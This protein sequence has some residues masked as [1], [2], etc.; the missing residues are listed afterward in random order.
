MGNRHVPIIL[1]ALLVALGLYAASLYSYLLFHSL[2]ELFSVVVACGIFMIAWNSRQFSQNSYLLFLGIAYLTVACVDTLHMLAYKGMGVFSGTDTNPGTQLWIAARYLEALSFL[3][4]LLLMEVKIKA[5][6]IFAGY[7][8]VFVFLVLSIFSWESFPACFVEGKGLTPFK[9]TSEYAICL[10]LAFSAF[11]LYRKRRLFDRE[12]L[13]LVMASLMITTASELLFTFYVHAYGLF[14]FMGHLLKIASFYLIYRAFI[15]AGLA[16]PYSLLFRN[17]KAS[18]EAW[19][20]GEKKYRAL[21]ETLREGIWAVD[22]DACTTYVNPRMAEMLGCEAGDILGKPPFAFM[23]ERWVEPCKRKLEGQDEDKGQPNDFEFI[24]KDGGRLHAHMVANPLRDGLGRFLGAIAAVSDITDRKRV[25]NNLKRELEVNAALAEL[26]KTLVS[27]SS[28]MREI[29]GMI[30]DKSKSLTGSPCGYASSIDP[31]TKA[32]SFQA[33]A[34]LSEDQCQN[35][36]AL[37]ASIRDH[38]ANRVGTFVNRL[39]G[40][41]QGSTPLPGGSVTVHRL[42]CVPV[43][44]GNEPVGQLAL[45]NKEGDYHEKD[46]EAVQRIAVHYAFAVQRLRFQEALR[47][48]HDELGLRVRQRTT[49]LLKINDELVKEI[50]VRRQAENALKASEAELR[51]LSGQLISAEERERKR[52]ALDL[53]DGI[54][55]TLSAIKF[56]T[57]SA[58]HRILTKQQEAAVAHL[59]SMTTMTQKAIEDVRRILMDLRPSILDDLG[60]LPTINWFCREFQKVYDHIRI[61][62]DIGLEEGDVPDHLK[63]VIFRVLQ[64]A[65]NNVAK[66]SRSNCVTLRLVKTGSGIEMVIQDEGVGFVPA[67]RGPDRET[68]GFGLAGMKERTELSGGKFEISSSRAGGTSVQALWPAGP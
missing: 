36:R 59:Q 21:V 35:I 46:L 50:A 58:L 31:L 4:S 1:S 67:G 27:P 2:A 44:L 11:L 52:I 49:Q 39:A 42:L 66:H 47:K 10:I 13:R 55:Q 38:S 23:E 60:I 25:E 64:E 15:R 6:W 16:K 17:L 18:E 8:T 20:A 7:G 45:A 61:I 37:C 56:S 57:E 26:Y 22:Q 14:N 24:R 12:F 51:H 32:V 29:A 9:K 48:S 19:K 63:I 33:A 68:K 43:V 54:G 3:F 65:F 53:H 30:L 34:G 5:R 62:K 40:E 41:E 28:T